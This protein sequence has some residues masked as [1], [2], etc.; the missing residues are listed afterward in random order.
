MSLNESHQGL[1]N[2][3]AITNYL[4]HDA[5][6]SGSHGAWDDFLGMGLFY[7]SIVYML[8]A[9]VAVC[10]GS[11]GGFVPR[12]MRQAQRDLG[13]ADTSRTILV[14]GNNPAAGWG[15][16]AWLNT[17]SFFRQRFPDIELLIDLT[18]KAQP[19]FSDNQISIDYLHIDADHSFDGCLHDFQAY[20]QFLHEG[21]LV[22]LHDTNFYRAG[23]KH[24]VEYLRTRADCEVIDFPDLGVGTALVRI[25]KLPGASQFRA[26]AATGQNQITVRRRA[27]ALPL[28]SPDTE[29]K[30]METEAFASRY[31]LAAHFVGPCRSVI[32]IGGAKTPI[33]VFLTGH[34]DSIVVLDPF[35][36]EHSRTTFNGKPCSVAHVRAR[37]QDVDW[38]V[39]ENT[40]FAMVMMGLEIQGLEPRDYEILYSLVNRAR[41]TVIEFTPSWAVSRDQFEMIKNKTNTEVTLR[42]GLDLEGNDF[43]DL[44]NSWPPRCDR[45][46]Y[47][48]EPKRNSAP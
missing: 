26:P 16:P 46:I 28:A 37:F 8:K 31:V 22:T 10:L 17:D 35:I 13:I 38:H 4:M 42:V 48:L 39:P 25:G 12:L 33:D 19:F 24:V 47:V 20:R 3:D 2:H 7:Y 43:G 45:S 9:R 30:Y 5:P 14:D 34:H 44:T 21:S 15:S 29:W 6:W 36:R 11:G 40:D 41:V 1:L 32:E 27:D 18:S 23:V